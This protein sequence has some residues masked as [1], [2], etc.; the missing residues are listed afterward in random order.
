MAEIK[1]L[2]EGNKVIYPLTSTQA[3]V[4]ENGNRVSILTE[5]RVEEMIEDKVTSANV[6]NIVSITQ[7]DYDALEAKDAT[8]LYLITE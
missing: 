1:Q 2:K 7:A 3:I 5:E 4:D 8:T 6:T